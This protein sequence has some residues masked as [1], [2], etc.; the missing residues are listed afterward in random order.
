MKILLS[1]QYLFHYIVMLNL[2]CSVSSRQK[3]IKEME[4]QIFSNFIVCF[5]FLFMSTNV[6]ISILYMDLSL[7]ANVTYAK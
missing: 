6:Y 7:S 1:T 5:Y 2:S 4:M 3:I